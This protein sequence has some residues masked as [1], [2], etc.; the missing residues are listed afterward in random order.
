MS[1]DRLRPLTSDPR[2]GHHFAGVSPD[3]RLIAYLS[4]R[5]NGID[6]DLWVCGLLSGEH[7]CCYAGG[8]FCQ[9]GSGFSARRSPRLGAP[10][11][12]PPA[13][14]G[15]RARRRGS[16]GEAQDPAR[17]SGRAGAWSARRRGSAATT[18]LRASS[19]VGRDFSA[20]VRYDLATGT[21]TPLA[22]TGERFDAEVVAS[23]DGGTI[24]VIENR[25]GASAV[26]RYDA[27]SGAPGPSVPLLEPGVVSWYFFPAPV[28]SPD[29]WRL[30]LHADDA[31]A[32]R[33]CLQL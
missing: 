14:R 24:V 33:R 4:N 20:I 26:Q 10:A 22:G 27:T 31:P 25:D 3:G 15:P 30:V 8:A 18:F 6:F 32:R 29:G 16:R 9:P 7:R 5:A 19:N 1:F 23:T 12:R 17:A 21:T 13:R 2:F 28:L 11:R